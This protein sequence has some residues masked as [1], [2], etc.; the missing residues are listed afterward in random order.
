MWRSGGRRLRCWF[1]CRE[2]RNKQRRC[3]N[4]GD[5]KALAHDLIL[6]SNKHRFFVEECAFR[7]NY[8]KH[9]KKG[10]PGKTSNQ[11]GIHPNLANFAYRRIGICT[12]VN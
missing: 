9:S 1:A 5:E 8:G 7:I 3:D 2:I 4:D 10:I 12:Y 11:Y 6:Q